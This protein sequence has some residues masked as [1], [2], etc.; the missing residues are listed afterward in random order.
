VPA[1]GNYHKTRPS[2]FKGIQKPLKHITR[3][4]S[5]FIQ[6][7]SRLIEMQSI[8]NGTILCQMY[9][10]FFFLKEFLSNRQFLM[11]D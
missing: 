8:F 10:F 4:L 9:T 2:P 7:C 3:Q 6:G 11:S 1:D 5:P